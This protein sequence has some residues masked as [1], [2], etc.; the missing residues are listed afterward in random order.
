MIDV[1][2]HLDDE[3]FDADR[4][5]VLR[6]AREA[7]IDVAILAGVDPEGWRRQAAL[8]RAHPS[9]TAESPALAFTAGVHP[10]V[11]AKDDDDSLD[12]MLEDLAAFVPASGAAGIGELGLDRSRWSP[13]ESLPRQER[14][15]RAQLALARDLDLPLN[16]HVVKA[17]ARALEILEADGLPRRGGLVHAYSGPAELVPRYLALGLHVSFSGTVSYPDAEKRRRAARAVPLDRL[18]VETDS[19]DMSPTPF[20]GAR[21]EPSRLPFVLAAL[22]EARHEDPTALLAATT[23]NARALFGL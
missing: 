13:P 1:H 2:G 18:L 3:S 6:R 4:A 15:F 22:A 12:R 14:A 21:N 11:V 5:A 23:R 7:G 16:L 17:H 9:P 8:V 19:P 10:G 20:R